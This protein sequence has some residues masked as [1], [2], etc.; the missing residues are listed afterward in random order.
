MTPRL[1]VMIV[2]DNMPG[3]YMPH[4]HNIKSHMDALSGTFIVDYACISSYNDFDIYDSI[5]SFKYKVTNN[6]KQLE[7]VC[8]FLSSCPE[9]YDWYIKTRPEVI[10][11]EVPDILSLSTDSINARLHGYIGPKKILFGSSVGGNGVWSSVTE[12][13]KYSENETHI[14]LD[15]QIYIFNKYVV[16]NGAFAVLTPEINEFLP[17]N[18]DGRQDEG[19]HNCVWIH[20]NIKRNPIRIHLIIKRI[21]S[22]GDTIF[23]G[24]SGHVNI[25]P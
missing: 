2:G 13:I 9:K 15:D 1:L 14:G 7:K 4:I 11:L 10:L 12:N 8:D 18:Y 16:D 19:I 22:N 3:Q 20:R 23:S 25:Q 17:R 21:D 6:K 24:E 5:L